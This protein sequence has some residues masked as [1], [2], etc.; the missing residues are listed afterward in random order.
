M[1]CVDLGESFQT[2]FFLQNLASIHPRTSPAKFARSSR[3]AVWL[4]QLKSPATCGPAAI[5]A[6]S[7]KNEAWKIGIVRFVT[8]G[9]FVSRCVVVSTTLRP[10]KLTGRFATFDPSERGRFD[11]PVRLPCSQLRS[12]QRNPLC[13]KL[14]GL[15]RE[16]RTVLAA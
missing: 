8:K 14:E 7:F 4:P 15:P 13:D 10:K 6:A 1:H 12:G 2:H 3:A 16:R 5:C 9:I 11:L